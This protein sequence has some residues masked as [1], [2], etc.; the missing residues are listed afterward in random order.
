MSENSRHMQIE[1]R[2]SAARTRIVRRGDLSAHACTPEHP[3]VRHV[4]TRESSLVLPSKTLDVTTLT[5]IGRVHSG[6]D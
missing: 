1:Q 5:T 3:D 2:L 6:H 4:N